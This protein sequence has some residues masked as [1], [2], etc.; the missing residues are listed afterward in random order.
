MKPTP[1]APVR[2][3]IKDLPREWQDWFHSIRAHVLDITVLAG[4]T[5]QRPTKG[6]WVGKSYFDTTL[7]KPVWLKTVSPVAWVD[8]TGAAA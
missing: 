4:P 7:N 2:T 5:A 1:P 3:P 6:L 8:A